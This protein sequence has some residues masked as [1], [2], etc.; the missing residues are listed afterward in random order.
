MNAAPVR[1]LPAWL[2]SPPVQPVTRWRVIA[3]WEL[4]RIPY[5]IILGVFGILS[6]TIFYSSILSSGVL[7]EGE[8]AV[9]PLALLVAPILANI[10]YTAV[11]IVEIA[12]RFL[13]P[14]MTPALGPA[15]FKIG[16]SFS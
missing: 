12:V 3:W 15:L 6:L 2:F 7:H 14:S 1:R 13:V 4:R 11:W 9:E 8:D 10:C 16:L 5:N